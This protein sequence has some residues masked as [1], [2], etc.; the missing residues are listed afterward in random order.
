MS[1]LD[2]QGLQTRNGSKNGGGGGSNLSVTS[3]SGGPGSNLSAT[4]CN[5]STH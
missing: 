3:C 2:L 1:V 4:L 5:S